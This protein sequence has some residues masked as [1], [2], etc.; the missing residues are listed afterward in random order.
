M[1]TITEMNTTQRIK[2]LAKAVGFHAIGVTR[3]EIPKEAE[4]RFLRWRDKGFSG[5]MKFIQRYEERKV[6]FLEECEG[7]KSVIVLGVNYNQEQDQSEAPSATS[8]KVA[9]YAWGE[10]YHTVIRKRHEI[11]I[12]QLKKDI[13]SSATYISSIDTR[14]LFERELAQQAGLGFIGKQNQLL[15]LDYG[16]WL[17]LSEII[18]DLELVSDKEHEGSCGTC[19]L[20]IDHC[21]TDAIVAEREL[22]ARKCISYLTIEHPGDIPNEISGK[23]GNWF[24]GCDDCLTICP[25]TAKSKETNWREF[26]KEKNE[27]NWIDMKGILELKSNKDFKQK[28]GHRALSRIN[29]NR[30]I[31]NAK[32]VLNNGVKS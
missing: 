25:Y 17:F 28:F 12:E 1:L 11:L 24:F 30:A 31:R 20:C 26:K 29:K 14:P 7:A 16:P 18:T 10:D 19:R 32:I 27:S 23:M 15:S 9:R 22:D 8:G 3:F 6:Q 13:D 5:D 21:P 4:K 2:E